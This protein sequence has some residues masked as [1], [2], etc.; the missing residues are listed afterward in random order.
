MPLPDASGADPPHQPDGQRGADAA[1]QNRQQPAE[2]RPVMPI[3]NKVISQGVRSGERGA[4][5]DRKQA[6]ESAGQGGAGQESAAVVAQMQIFVNLRSGLR[7][8]KCLDRLPYGI[9]NG[10][11]RH[12]KP[13]WL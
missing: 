4:E 3:G 2:R 10:W 6:G 13:L 7:R 12:R 9:G 11:G 1:E 5:G 8:A